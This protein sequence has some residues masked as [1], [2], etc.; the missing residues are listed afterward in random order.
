MSFV[1]VQIVLKVH[2]PEVAKGFFEAGCLRYVLKQGAFHGECVGAE[3]IDD[4]AGIL[5]EFADNLQQFAQAGE[6][7]LG[8]LAALHDVRVALQG[9][10][11]GKDWQFRVLARQLC[12][13]EPERIV[14]NVDRSAGVFWSAC[15]HYG[16]DENRGAEGKSQQ[17]GP[18]LLS[19][20][21]P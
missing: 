6:S 10:P 12:P 16:H 17:V 4:D 5:P 18:V 20:V 7:C 19:A 14:V 8:L 13:I 21:A 3:R 9:C 15:S 11:I 2:A 1:I